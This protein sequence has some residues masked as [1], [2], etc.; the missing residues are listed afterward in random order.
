MIYSTFLRA[1][2]LLVVLAMAAPAT[3]D[4]INLT[5]SETASNIAEIYVM[6]DHVRLVLEVYVGDLEV[7]AE[8]VPDDWLND[9][10]VSRPDEATRLRRFAEERFQFIT[11]SG[12]KLPA[13]VLLVEPRERVDRR[14]P[15]AGMINPFTRQRVPEAPAD[16]RILYAELRYPFDGKP[17]EL[18]IIP[19]QDKE[20]RAEVTIGFIVYHKSVPV[21]DF[22][23]LG[24]P[25]K[26]SLDW[27]DPWY[28]KF[29][30]PNLKRHLGPP[31][32]I[33]RRHHG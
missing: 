30:N 28:S 17:G 27:D 18:T 24:A 6:D 20:G 7:F 4:W 13:E 9:K 19:P 8:L 14:S 2:C 12:E 1:F 33:Q 25:A 15:F 23:Y 3:A 22:R 10:P 32:R 29:D 5:G 11:D 31:L 21:I 26:L 16:K